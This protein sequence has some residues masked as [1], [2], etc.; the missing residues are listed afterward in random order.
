MGGLAGAAA[1]FWAARLAAHPAV[2]AGGAQALAEAAGFIW[3][4]TD[5]PRSDVAYAAAQLCLQRQDFTSLTE[6]SKLDAP[7]FF[8]SA[9]SDLRQSH[10]AACDAAIQSANKIDFFK[11]P[12]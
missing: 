4:V 5:S 3:P 10:S 2:E 1:R 7:V 12:W 11:V 9:M 6:H 8:A